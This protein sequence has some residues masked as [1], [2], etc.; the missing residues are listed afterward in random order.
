MALVTPA[1]QTGRQMPATPTS[2]ESV[3][4]PKRRRPLSGIRAR[5]VLGYVALL[6]A[7]LTIA[8]LVTRQALITRLYNDIDEALVHEI[9]ELRAL[10]ANGVNPTTGEPLGSDVEAIFETFFDRN[11]PGD[12]EAYYALVDG[13]PFLLSYNAPQELFRDRELVDTWAAVTEPLRAEADTEAGAIRYVAVPLSGGG[14]PEGVYVVV[15]FPA[16]DL[17]EVRQVARIIALV[18]AGVL[19]ASA[20]VAWS[21]AGR[22][23]RP[24]RELTNAARSVTK[25]DL[26]R[27]IP[28]TGHDELAELG[29]R[30]NEMLDRLE[31]GFKG[32]RQFLDD[33]AHELRTPIT[34]ARGHLE[35]LGDDPDERA[36]T[37]AVVTDELDRM[38]RYVND[39]LLLAKAEQ[40]E[41]LHFEPVDVGELAGDLTQRVSGIADRRWV[42]DAA[43]EPGQLAIVADAGRLTQAM[44][45][46]ASNAVEHTDHGDEIG[47]GFETV[48]GNGVSPMVRMWVRDT[49][50]GVDP[51]IV[52]HLFQRHV[53]GAASRTR[54]TEGMGIGL[55]IVDVI[56]R[57]HNGVVDVA[58]VDG[59]GARFTMTI[60]IDAERAV[61]EPAGGEGSEP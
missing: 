60:P 28:V 14:G 30:F 47:L 56:A 43:P 33:V 12:S 2:D 23:V 10:T 54:R 19:V 3:T 57:A 9:E 42:L 46:L 32:Q 7:A 1:R 53:R 45:N 55:S 40:Q 5:I 16:D 6:A 58:N 13:D 25:D 17:A 39:L 18:S 61:E 8:V 51:T 24:I 27:R 37:I 49:G 41:L 21:L 20:L 31:L 59:G 38:N 15:H 48:A 11:V 34:I 26:S 4:E 22:V 44:L 29:D 35:V 50:P 52:D 36:E